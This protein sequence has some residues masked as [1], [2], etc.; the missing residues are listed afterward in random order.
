MLVKAVICDQGSN[1]RSMVTELWV[2]ADNPTFEVNGEIQ[3]L[4]DPPHLLQNI[5]NNLTK[6]GFVVDDNDISWEY[7][8]RFYNTD[9]QLLIQMAPKLTNISIPH[10][11]RQCG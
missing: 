2:D 10:L 4:F 11:S 9:S 7:I 5:Q 8:E 3:V 1:N 6:L